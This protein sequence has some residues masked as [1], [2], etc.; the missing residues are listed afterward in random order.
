M[1]RVE[2]EIRDEQPDNPGFLIP[3]SKVV[4]GLREEFPNIR[5]EN[6]EVMWLENGLGPASCAI[7]AAF[8]ALPGRPPIAVSSDLWSGLMDETERPATIELR[9]KGEPVEFGVF[10]SGLHFVRG[11]RPSLERLAKQFEAARIRVIP[12][13]EP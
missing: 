8:Q 13:Q 4:N 9:L 3:F 1:T 5:P 7:D 2:L 12:D 10:D 6:L 11:P